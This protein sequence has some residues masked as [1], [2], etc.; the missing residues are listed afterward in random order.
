MPA[1][2]SHSAATR[3]GVSSRTPSGSGTTTKSFSVPWPLVK[4]R[5]C[6]MLT[7][8]A[9]GRPR[10]G[11]TAS[12]ASAS[13]SSR[14]RVASS[15]TT[16]SS[17]R[18]HFSCRRANARV[19]RTVSSRAWSRVSRPSRWSSTWAYPRARDAVRP[20]RRPAP[21]RV[22]T[23]S[24]RPSSSIRSTRAS[25]RSSSSSR[26]A[27]RPTC[28]VGRTYAPDGSVAVN[29]RPVSS[30]TSRARTTRRTLVG[31]IAAAAAGSR[32]ASSA[33]RAWGPTRSACSCHRARTCGSVPGNSSGSS[34]ARTYSPDPPT[35]TGTR[36]AASRPSIAARA[37]R[38]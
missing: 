32:S 31:R 4:R 38:W 33:C 6:S 2:R 30:T 23:S 35:S 27:R 5:P 1:R 12:R 21:S 16:R 25:M 9:Y 7:A 36:P 15:H 28:T 17:R 19:A 37:S 14:P 13:S 18:N 10:A 26:G 11:R 8:S 34:A 20:S 22:R 29:G 24:T 3:S